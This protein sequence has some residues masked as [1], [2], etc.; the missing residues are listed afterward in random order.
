M[1][2]TK[3]SYDGAKLMLRLHHQIAPTHPAERGF[4][5]ELQPRILFLAIWYYHKALLTIHD[6]VV[7]DIPAHVAM[8]YSLAEKNCDLRR[9][10]SQYFI[11]HQL[12]RVVVLE[13]KQE[14]KQDLEFLKLYL[15]N[16][17]YRLAAVLDY[18]FND[19]KGHWLDHLESCLA[20]LLPAGVLVEKW[21]DS[22][23]QKR[24]NLRQFIIDEVWPMI[25]TC[26]RLATIMETA[27]LSL[28][29]VYI[30]LAEHNVKTKMEIK[31][32][33]EEIKVSR[34]IQVRGWISSPKP[35]E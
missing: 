26:P 12:L 10:W 31:E 35:K 6:E 3:Q 2:P 25:M 27:K 22:F 4:I 24:W 29:L 8:C 1:Q 19:P 14:K 18:S 21:K 15:R 11:F 33:L 7:K 28:V 9:A 13:E 5:P 34:N 17:E 30:A 23:W 32:W 20:K 16:M